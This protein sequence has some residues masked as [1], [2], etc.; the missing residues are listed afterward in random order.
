MALTRM[1]LG[2]RAE[3]AVAHY[4]LEHGA[5]IVAR[6][7]RLGMLEIDV[8]ARLDRLVLVVEVRF[9]SAQSWTSGFS[10]IDGKKRTRIRRAGE[11][12][13]NRRYRNDPTVDR[14]RFDA[15]SVTFLNDVPNI[16][17]MSGAF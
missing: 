4:L 13:W 16:E 12:L 10:S 14:L 5:Q 11:R 8:V 7:L 3:D 6:N 15:A 9:R 1:D 2:R 17:Y